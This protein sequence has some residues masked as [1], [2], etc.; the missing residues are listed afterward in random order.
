MIDRRHARLLVEYLVLFYGVVGLFILAGSPGGPIPPLVVLAVAAWLM[1][2]RDP[3]FEQAN[4]LRAAAVPGQVR[5]IVA[6]WGL[7]VVV[8]VV[9][10][11]VV[12]PDRLFDL[13]RRMPLLWVAVV[14]LYPLVSV[15]PQE[16]I[17][18]AFLLHRYGP[19][20]GGADTRGAAAAGTAAFGFAHLMFGSVWSVLL[21]LI[22]GWLF[23]RR[24]QR[25]RSLLAAAVEHALYGVLAFTV[26]LGDLFYHGATA[27]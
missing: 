11:A 2:R 13:P 12:A 18:R 7:A 1:L 22:G 9:A 24:Y 19:V 8:S 27:R 25:S 14:V 15:Y 4:L 6:L 17:Y 26:G 16:L 10:I 21:T 3:T 20:F 23:A 5:S